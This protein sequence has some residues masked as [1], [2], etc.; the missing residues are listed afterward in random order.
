MSTI[1]SS[2]TEFLGDALTF[3]RGTGNPC[4]KPHFEGSK[5]S[6]PADPRGVLTVPTVKV[7]AFLN[8]RF[9]YRP[10]AAMLAQWAAIQSP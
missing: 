9:R 8:E 5:S 7:T 3:A 4:V 1:N 6:G 10:T 2:C